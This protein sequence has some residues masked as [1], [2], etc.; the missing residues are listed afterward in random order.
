VTS[1][2]DRARRIAGGRRE[3]WLV[4]LLVVLGLLYPWYE[5]TLQSLPLIGDFVPSTESMVV[6]IALTMMAVGALLAA[7]M[8]AFI[9]RLDPVVSLVAVRCR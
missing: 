5:E 9:L 4:P 6:M 3:T 8:S 7:V 2:S 1:L